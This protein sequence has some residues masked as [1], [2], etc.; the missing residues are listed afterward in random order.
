MQ[1]YKEFLNK[2]M[3]HGN[4]RGDRTGTG[5]VSLFGPQMEFDL[6]HGFPLLTCKDMS[7]T[8]PSIIHELLWFLN[9]DTHLKY[10]K[11]NNVGIWDADAHRV[12]RSKGGELTLKEFKAHLKKD[13]D[14][15]QEVGSLGPI[16]GSQ[17][18]SWGVEGIDQISDVL[19]QLTNNPES[20]RILVSA[21]NV[22]DLEKMTL[23][24]CHILFQF[25]VANGKLDCKLYQRSADTF[26]G[27][28][29][30]IASY[31][32]L[33]MMVAK[34][35]GLEPGRFIHTFG[36]AHVYLNHVDQVRELL[37]REDRPLPTLKIDYHGQSLFDFKIEDFTLD[38]YNPHGE[39][40]GEVS[41]GK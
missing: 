28:P 8:L 11:D 15:L 30:N 38:G 14:F 10:L 17:W 34:V 19:S 27:V 5:T 29:F 31:A 24:P 3:V 21:W 6:A 37:N 32:L 16:Y 20:R 18:R 1:Q 7:K 26:L 25:Y 36:D 40:R 22:S 23:P 13:A 9:G 39:L 35:V 33:T 41:V 12:Y 4:M 2:I